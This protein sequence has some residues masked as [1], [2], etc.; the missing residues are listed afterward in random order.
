MMILSVISAVLIILLVFLW[1]MKRGQ[2]TVKAYVFL[3]SIADG[4]TVESA[5]EL[6]KRIDLYAASELRKK[7]L[8]IVDAAFEGNQ[9]KFISHARREGFLE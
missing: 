3:S 2:K 9:L 1:S 4:H 8:V 5:N 6:A 7:A